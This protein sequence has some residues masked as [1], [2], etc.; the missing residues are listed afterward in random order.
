[1]RVWYVRVWDPDVRGGSVMDKSVRG[2]MREYV[3]VC[4]CVSGPCSVSEKN[5]GV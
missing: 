3:H 2:G 5:T 4:T 1:M